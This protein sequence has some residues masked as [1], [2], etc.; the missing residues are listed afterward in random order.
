MSSTEIHMEVLVSIFRP[1][2]RSNSNSELS[3]KNSEN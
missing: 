2:E 1:M 3:F